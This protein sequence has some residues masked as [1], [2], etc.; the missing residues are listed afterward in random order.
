VVLAVSA[1]VDCEPETPLVPAQPPLAV[2]DVAFVA[3]QV[4]VALLPLATVLGLL[5]KLTVG[6]ACLTDTVVDCVAVPP[7]PVQ[8]NV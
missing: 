2:Q 5:L 1:P 6:A 4:R 7:V 3:D 8:D